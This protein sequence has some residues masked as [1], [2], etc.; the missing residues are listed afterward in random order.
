M[1]ILR[2]LAAIMAVDVVGFSRLMGEDEAGTA[3]SVR[4]HRAA[5]LP[6]VASRGGRIV[7]VDLSVPH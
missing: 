1:A 5:A 4:E 7:K 2:K 3:R 6:L